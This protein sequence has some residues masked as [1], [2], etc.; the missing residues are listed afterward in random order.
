[1]INIEEVKKIKNVYEDIFGNGNESDC[2]IDVII[3]CNDII[4]YYYKMGTEIDKLT[5]GEFTNR[6]HLAMEELERLI[7]KEES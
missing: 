1:M 6:Y 2:V 7:K 3:A 5:W 4:E